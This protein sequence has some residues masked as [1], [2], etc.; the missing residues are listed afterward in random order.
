MNWYHVCF[1]F[2]ERENA[3]PLTYKLL[4]NDLLGGRGWWLV[5]GALVR[6][7]FLFQLPCVRKSILLKYE[8]K[9]PPSVSWRRAFFL[10]TSSRNTSR[11]LLRRTRVRLVILCGCVQSA[12]SYQPSACLPLHSLFLVI[13]TKE[14]SVIIPVRTECRRFNR[15]QRQSH[16][17]HS[18]LV[19]RDN[20]AEAL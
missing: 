2:Y 12:V 7:P 17:Y 6:G 4:I 16:H 9:S 3:S 14:L 18:S 5:K 11:R 20:K 8:T 15:L 10:V 13:A 1:T 19:P